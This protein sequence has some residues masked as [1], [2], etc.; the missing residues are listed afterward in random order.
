MQKIPCPSCN[1]PNFPS[2]VMCW[3]CGA[4]LYKREQPAP[5]EP[6]PE[7]TPQEPDEVPAEQAENAPETKPNAIM[8]AIINLETE[9]PSYRK[10]FMLALFLAPVIGIAANML[11]SIP[12]YL[13]LSADSLRSS[14]AAGF[15]VIS[16]IGAA[17]A[18]F[19]AVYSGYGAAA[20]MV[21]Y[22]ISLILFRLFAI[23]PSVIAPP[24]LWTYH[25]FSGYFI[26]YTGM[27]GSVLVLRAMK[28]RI[29]PPALSPKS[30]LNSKPGMAIALSVIAAIVLGLAIPR[31]RD[32]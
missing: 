14:A 23:S 9:G 10:N 7:P 3:K 2:D 24:E 22:G 32:S 30:P 28:R 8:E 6:E 31:Y 25:L 16:S 20:G 5:A 17:A 27:F 29:V 19:A 1:E 4:P 11:F 12:F 21:V 26:S 13:W 18:G 15:I